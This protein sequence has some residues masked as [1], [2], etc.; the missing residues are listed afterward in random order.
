MV[1]R[2]AA[3]STRPISLL[4]IAALAAAG[5]WMLAPWGASFGAGGIGSDAPRPE[6]VAGDDV[7]VTAE[8]GIVRRLVVPVTLHGSD[9]IALGDGA[10]RAET[11]MSDTAVAAV[12][13]TYTVQWTSADDDGVLEPGEQATITVE[14]PTSTSVLPHNPLDLVLKPTAGGTLVIEDVLP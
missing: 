13:V 9:G 2:P 10:G 4:L 3:H 11:A 1:L 7:Q 6:I 8:A 14:L 12:P 5:L